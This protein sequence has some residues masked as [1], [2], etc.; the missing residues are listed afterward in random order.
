MA[1]P[2]YKYNLPTVLIKNNVMEY[3]RC[4]QKIQP[5]I[6]IPGILFVLKVERIKI[7]YD[8]LS[9]VNIDILSMGVHNQGQNY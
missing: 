9:L 2:P 6:E 7:I 3:I 8:F 4:C 5:G 1:F